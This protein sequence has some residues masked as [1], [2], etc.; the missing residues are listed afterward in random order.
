VAR[1]GA[2]GAPTL[3][4]EICDALIEGRAQDDDVCVLT[5]H[6]IP[7]DVMFSRS[8]RAAP[9]ELAGL[10][11]ALREWL[12]ERGVGDDVGRGVV[13]AVSEAAT[14][15]VEHA[16]RVRRGRHRHRHGATRGRSARHHRPRRGSWRE[17][18]SDADRGRGLAIMRAIVDEVTIERDDAGTVRMLQG[19]HELASA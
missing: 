3:A 2:L 14:N 17:G 19:A 10:R 8:F 6:R 12:V 1:L 5:I 13:L 15:A 18:G 9:S 16:L 7:N 4:D 11:E